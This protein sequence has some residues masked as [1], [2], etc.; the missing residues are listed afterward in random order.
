MDDDW[1]RQL[2][3]AEWD[4]MCCEHKD[5]AFPKGALEQRKTLMLRRCAAL[6]VEIDGMIANAIADP[7]LPD[8][9]GWRF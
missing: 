5:R 6:K 3:D 7:S 9:R 2:E 4:A 8:P 1:D